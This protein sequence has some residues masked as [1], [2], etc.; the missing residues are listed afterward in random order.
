MTAARPLAS[1]PARTAVVGLLVA[2]LAAFCAAAAAG[3]YT[4]EHRRQLKDAL[5][6]LGVAARHLRSDES[7][8]AASAIAE[9]EAIVATIQKESDYPADHS[10]FRSYN[11]ILES[12]RED[13]AK[14]S[15][16]P[17]AES[18]S[19]GMQRGGMSGGMSGGM[20]SA[21]GISFTDDVAPILLDKCTRCHG[22][23]RQSAGLRLDSFAAL[24]A[25]ARGGPLVTPGNPDRSLLLARIMTD[26]VLRRMPKNGAALPNEE[27]ITIGRWIREGAA[28]DGAD[29][30]AMLGSSAAAKPRELPEG[31]VIPKPT[32]N[33]TVS[34]T[35]DIAPFFVEM[36]VGCHSGPAARSDFSLASFHDMMSG[37]A[38]GE[39]VIPG[40]RE[41]SRLFRL[42]GGLE[43][44]RMPDSR[45]RLTRK[46][47][48]DLKTWFD[49]GCVFDGDDPKAL[50]TSYVRSESDGMAAAMSVEEKLKADLKRVIP[51]ITFTHARA[52]SP[53]GPIYVG[54]D[55]DAGELTPL[56]EAAAD[57]LA[58]AARAAGVDFTERGGLAVMI[59]EK[60]YTY[61]EAARA[62]LDRDAP[63]RPPHFVASEGDQITA[64]VRVD[65]STTTRGNTAEDL[66][67][68]AMKEAVATAQ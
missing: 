4:P 36:C 27:I 20:A 38:S 16:E 65:L 47:Y 63:S 12:R 44:P 29:E 32:G 55:L 51:S 26:D 64:V 58:T 10:V 46:N 6:K 22:A 8:E 41:N 15:G 56:A 30:S 62:L 61:G 66:V 9:A 18:A 52:D 25:N 59:F 24:K 28:Y 13:L 23:G 17:A 60:R 2:S 14:L 49:E 57:E 37:G 48:E 1:R 68:A 31:V 33:E 43:L 35:R 42:T 40:D 67:R 53:V 50:L 19:D 5:A 7:K 11:R 45:M 3:E 21:D 34:F 39:V 54:S